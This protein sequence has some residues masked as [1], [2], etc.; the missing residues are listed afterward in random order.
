MP[1]VRRTS[2]GIAAVAGPDA[3]CL[4]AGVPV[5]GEGLTTVSEFVV[6][7]GDRVPFVLTWHPSHQSAPERLDAIGEIEDTERWWTEWSRALHVRGAVARRA[8]SAR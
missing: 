8:C 7:Q 1:W 3:I 6:R 2:D 4:H 5:R